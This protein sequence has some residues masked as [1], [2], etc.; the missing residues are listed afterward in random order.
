M[1][2]VHAAGPRNPVTCIPATLI[3]ARDTQ[4]VVA[5]CGVKRGLTVRVETPQTW[6]SNEEL[7]PDSIIRN[8]IALNVSEHRL[9]KTRSHFCQLTQCVGAATA[10]AT[11]LCGCRCVC[12]VDVLR[13][14]D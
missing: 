12:H 10:M 7:R 14:N 3:Y 5:R 13:P 11:W 9:Q 1:K 6:H 4:Q 8:F 2:V